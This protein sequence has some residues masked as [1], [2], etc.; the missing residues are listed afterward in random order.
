MYKE[1]TDKYMI[2][3]GTGVNYIGGESQ[4]G[5]DAD[6]FESI[7]INKIRVHLIGNDDDYWI[8]CAGYFASRGFYVIWGQT[9]VSSG[10]GSSE[11]TWDAYVTSVMA[12]AALSESYKISEFQIGNEMHY[13]IDGT[14]LTQ[15]QLRNKLRSLA[16]QVKGVFSG[17]ISYSFDVNGE[18]ENWIS[19]GKGDIDKIGFNYYNEWTSGRYMWYTGVNPILPL[20][21]AEFSDSLYLTEYN[22]DSDSDRTLSIPA[23][24]KIREFRTLYKII[25]DSGVSSAYIFQYSGWKSESDDGFCMRLVNGSFSNSWDIIKTDNRRRTFFNV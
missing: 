25:K 9:N 11:A 24:I 15:A 18:G 12:N 5:I 7:G 22:L 6:Y 14:T 4:W 8:A 17:V 19:E 20:L 2:W 23:D 10:R 3:S 13:R 1:V 21:V 16:T